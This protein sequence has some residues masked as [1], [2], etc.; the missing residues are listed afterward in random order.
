MEGPSQ[1][2]PSDVQPML[3][4]NRSETPETSNDLRTTLAEFLRPEPGKRFRLQAKRLFLTY[5]QCPLAREDVLLR[6]GSL[7]LP[8]TIKAHLIA[9]ETH[10]DGNTHLHVFLELTDRF[11]T[12][13]A[14]FFDLPDPTT[15]QKTHHP[16]TQAVRSPTAVQAYLL[17]EDPEP[18]IMGLSDAELAKAKRWL[19]LKSKTSAETPTT[20]TVSEY[21]QAM[22][23]MAETGNLSEA[24]EIIRSTKRGARDLMIS[25]EAIQ[26]N[27]KKLRPRKMT[28]RYTLEDFPGWTINWDRKKTLILTGPPNTGK[29]ALAK[30][31][32]PDGL[33]VTHVDQLRDYDS[34]LSNGIIFDEGSFKHIPREAQIHVTD[35]EEDRTV[36][37]RY[38][39]AFLP[40][41]TLRIISSNGSPS[42]ILLWN[43]YAIRRRCQWVEVRDINVYHNYG[44]PSSEDEHNSG[45]CEKKFTWVH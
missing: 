6:L 43:D 2:T 4:E 14:R 18:L 38:A 5:S 36:H 26:R 19:S 39:P 27:L 22:T 21:S 24:L 11:E 20:T 1:P 34:A 32:L 33:F 16:N 29:T 7:L 9:R 8:N 25:G 42:D 35:V 13:D 31:L 23:L 40:A 28:L 17:K 41:G 30:A 10:A 15:P 45:N 3:D 12:R 37:C 44:T